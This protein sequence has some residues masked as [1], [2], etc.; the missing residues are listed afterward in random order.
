[1]VARIEHS[2]TV[3]EKFCPR[4]GTTKSAREF[5]VNRRLKKDGLQKWC[6]ACQKA[7]KAGHPPRPQRHG[8]YRQFKLRDRGLS[9]RGYE[10]LREA[11]D[12]RCALCGKRFDKLV[13]DHDHATDAVRGLLCHGCNAALGVIERPDW[14]RK[15]RQ[16]LGGRLPTFCTEC[17]GL[18]LGRSDAKYCSA[19]CRT[20]AK[21]RSTRARRARWKRA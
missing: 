17:G 13:V 18:V 16:Y 1:M 7:W 10:A 8:Y 21:T 19:G 2:V 5:Y 4:C 14:L 9:Q 20:G 6:K 11:Q 12:D 3:T 15:A